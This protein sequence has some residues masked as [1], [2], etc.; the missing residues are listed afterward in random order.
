MAAILITYPAEPVQPLETAT[1]SHLT[2][3]GSQIAGYARVGDRLG[4]FVVT[5]AS[6][7]SVD[8]Y[9]IHL[10]GNATVSGKFYERVYDGVEIDDFCFEPD[11]E[12]A[13]SIPRFAEDAQS[14]W[15]CFENDTFARQ[16]L[17]SSSIRGGNGTI[18]IKDYVYR[19]GPNEMTD[20][21][22]FVRALE[23]PGL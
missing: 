9:E 17:L 11:E 4:D 10:S 7:H 23:S 16:G 6:Y 3:S 8:D 22:T 20:T 2:H 18:V 15:F 5:S 19:R 21:A 13:S 14:H 1:T 12:A